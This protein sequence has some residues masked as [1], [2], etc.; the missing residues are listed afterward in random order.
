[1]EIGIHLSELEIV[2]IT[3]GMKLQVSGPGGDIQDQREE[4][5]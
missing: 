1:M 5:V 3:D 4:L 2:V